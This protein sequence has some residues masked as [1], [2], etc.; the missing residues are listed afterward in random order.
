MKEARL[1]VLMY[2]NSDLQNLQTVARCSSTK[3]PSS[4]SDC[5][6]SY[7]S[8]CRTGSFMRLAQKRKS[9][10]KCVSSAPRIG[11]WSEK[12]RLEHFVRPFLPPQGCLVYPPRHCVIVD[13]ISLY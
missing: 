1:P 6:P 10:S 9:K 3:L 8:C 12:F 11:S 4:I 7:Y 5:N 2:G 13:A